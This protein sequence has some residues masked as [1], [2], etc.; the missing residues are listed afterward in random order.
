VKSELIHSQLFTQNNGEGIDAGEREE[1]GGVGR[2]K[3]D[4]AAVL[5]VALVV[6]LPNE[7]VVHWGAAS[8]ADYFIFFFSVCFS[9]GSSSSLFPV[10]FIFASAP[11]PL[12]FLHFSF[13]PLRLFF[14]SSL[15]SVRLCFS[16]FSPLF[17]FP[18]FLSIFLPPKLLKSVVSIPLSSLFFT[19]CNLFF[20]WSCSSLYNVYPFFF[21]PPVSWTISPCPKSSL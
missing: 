18:F 21:F 14:F 6:L 9:S 19:F 8:P 4:P 15:L 1:G 11:P 13:V 5:T 2:G 17:L 16:L 3:A 20:L 10:F 7:V 12:C